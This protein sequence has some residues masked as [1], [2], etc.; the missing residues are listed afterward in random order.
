MIVGHDDACGIDDESRAERVGLA[1]L[2]FAVLVTAPVTAFG[3]GARTTA[4]L[5]KIVEEFLEWRARWQ[6]RHRAPAPAAKPLGLN[7]L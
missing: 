4:V 5:E 1:R 6:L 3:T 7:G 2:Q